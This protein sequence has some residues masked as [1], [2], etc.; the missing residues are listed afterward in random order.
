MFAII[1]YKYVSMVYHLS[2]FGF[3]FFFKV[4]IILDR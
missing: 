4:Y 1:E 2:P 3:C